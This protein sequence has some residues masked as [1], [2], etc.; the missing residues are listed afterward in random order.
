MGSVESVQGVVGSFGNGLGDVVILK[1]EVTGNDFEFM[2]SE[3]GDGG[4]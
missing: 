2:V 4:Y 1:F 3:V